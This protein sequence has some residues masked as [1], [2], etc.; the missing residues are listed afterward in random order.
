MDG[1]LILVRKQEANPTH[2]GRRKMKER[3]REIKEELEGDK[4]EW[5]G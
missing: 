1:D 5:I 2:Q 3:E 4:V